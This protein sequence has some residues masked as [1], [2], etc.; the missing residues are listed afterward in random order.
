MNEIQ[1]WENVLNWGFAQNTGFPSNLS[2]FSKDDFNSLKNTLQKCIP[3]VRFYSNLTSRE[4]FRNVVPYKKILPKEL[5]MNLLKTY[6]DPDD[7]PNDKP[8]P[9]KGINNSFKLSSETSLQ[10]QIFINFNRIC[11]KI[12]F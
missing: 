9:R 5:Y 1:V 4:F 12:L 6:L 10:Y 7:E 11:F 2:N 8:K 3:Y